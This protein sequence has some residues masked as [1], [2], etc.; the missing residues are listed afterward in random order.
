MIGHGAW[1]TEGSPAKNAARIKAPVL[2]FHGD[3][4]TNVG[5][6]ESRLMANRL[7]EAGDK[8]EL[9]EFKGLDHQLD[10]STARAT[11]LSKADAFLRSS[12]G[13]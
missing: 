11:L 13:M 5:I 2:L 6:G 7:K 9:V 12:M 3:L 1:V 8:V 10:D 4:D